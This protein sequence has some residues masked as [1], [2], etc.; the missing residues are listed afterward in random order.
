MRKGTGFPESTIVA[1]NGVELEV[2]EAG[3]ENTG[4]PIVLCHG[5]P[6]HAFSWRH[7]MP[8]LAAAG[9]HVIVPN[10]R[11]YGNSSRPSDITAYDIEHLTGDLVGLLDHFGYDSAI[12]FGHDWG[13]MVATWLTLLHPATVSAATTT[14]STSIDNRAWR[15]TSWT[16]THGDSLGTCFERISRLPSHSRGWQ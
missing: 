1:V 14:S 7:Q 5:W 9:Y 6:E 12:F 3:Q 15:M 10:Q 8:V 16:R 11:G 2:F 4:N 13:A